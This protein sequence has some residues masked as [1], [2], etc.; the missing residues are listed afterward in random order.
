MRSALV[1]LLLASWTAGLG[2]PA[3]ADGPVGPPNRY[4]LRYARGLDARTVRLTFGP[5]FVKRVA[6]RPETY[7][8]VC[9]ADPAYRVGL[10]ALAARCSA[11]PDDA[12]PAA[13]RGRRYE[14]NAVLLTL[15]RPMRPGLRYAV[16]A[17]GSGG[18]PVT[19]GRAAAW[20]APMSDAEERRAAADAGLGVRAME[21]LA[22]TVVR[23]T[24][25]DSF[26]TARFDGHPESIVLR[27][28]DDAA[29]RGGRAAVRVGRAS[30]GD[31]F[32][33]DGWPYG[34]F[35]V[36]EVFAEFDKP[37]REG[38]AYTLDLN[39]R[40]P[41]TSGSPRA[42]LR[43]DSRATISPAIKVNQ[44]GYLPDVPRRYA[45]LGAW[46]GSLGALDY[47]PPPRFEVRDAVSHAVLLRGTA[48]LRHRAGERAE[49]P[50]HEDLSGE[51]VCE[52]DLA[53]LNRPGRYYLA[54]PGMGRS[55]DFRVASDV[56]AGPFRVMMA[57]VLHQRCGIEMRPPYSAHYRPACH[58]NRTELTDLPRG[59]EADAF[60]EL[61][62]HV[63]D[64]RK[65]DRFGGHHDAGDYN[66]RSHLDVAELAF[67]AYET[68]PGAFFD[69]Q[70]PVPEAGNGIADILD[71]GRWALDLWV[72]L[73][74]ADGGVRNGTESDGDPDM[75]TLA[76]EDT[77]RDFA[78]ASDAV[79]S[80]RF[81]ASA[82]Q[83]ALLWRGLGREADA[84]G[85]LARA[86]RAWD[87]AAAHGADRQP[88]ALA[89]AAAQ[90]YRVTGKPVYRDAFER[91]CVFASR[92]DAELDV[93]QQYD[94]RDA[95][96]WYAFCRRPVDPELKRRILAAFRRR[97]DDWERWGQT[98]GYRR[99]RHPWAPNTWGTGGHPIWLVDA[100]EA[101]VLLRDPAIR[102]WM[103]LTCDWALGCNP[104]GTVFTTRLGQ[105]SIR[106]PLHIYS[107]YA[108]DGPIPGIQSEG[109]SPR[110]GGE[111]ATSSMST[112]IGAMLYP[113]GAWPPLQTYSDVG[114]VPEMNE[115]IVSN[116]MKSAV[117]YAALLPGRPTA[118][119]AR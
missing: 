14:R 59:S 97:M 70:L 18:Q 55:Y 111:A 44:I 13:W 11:A 4:G 40:T 89:L 80:L 87:W 2:A 103:A 102:S 16:Q 99:L 65:R 81:A 115:G 106:E 92:P 69:G 7:R 64:P 28:G 110:T 26:D 58:R 118:R 96:F 51:N 3:M 95:G 90:L 109:P 24:V 71:E 47:G 45:Y 37:L 41:L 19:G 42:S 17:L 21:I 53:G 100:V 74:E 10:R 8:I 30:R 31:C 29:F 23:L 38:R 88:D 35:L 76:E 5:S 93:W 34:H 68:N 94:Q 62:R 73:Q 78:F 1:L 61:P 83:A 63:I 104:M 39:A 60:R 67:L 33:T 43:V 116:Q 50:Y 36:H 82:A 20:I 98:E 107:R 32:Q 75:T 79:G 27:S 86:V 9:R 22:P 54:L 77:R 108:P 66:P 84:R 15:P 56:Y 101:G 112:W 114:L 46:M 49:G 72:R 117:A 85:L 48:R 6:E 25:G 12:P 52:M 105:R 119:S 113:A 57:G 91:H